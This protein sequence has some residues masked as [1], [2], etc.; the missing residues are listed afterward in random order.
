MD[1]RNNPA[2]IR[3]VD[4]KSVVKIS[5][6]ITGN[7]IIIKIIMEVIK[8]KFIKGI[9]GTNDI[10][11][12]KQ[13]QIAFIGRSNVGK[14]TLI[15]KLIG[16]KGLVKTSGQPGKTQQINFFLI[17]EDLP[18]E[19]YFVDLPG[20]GYAKISQKHREKM[21]K[22]ILWYFISGEANIK[23]V[24]LIIDAKSGLKDFDIEMINVLRE[25]GHDFIII[26]NKVDKLNQKQYHK[27]LMEIKDELGEDINILPVSAK[28][29]RGRDKVLEWIGE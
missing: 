9:V 6:R 21:R 13:D 7:L 4:L 3:I 22:M 25:Y 24:V 10:L 15:N 26:A 11:K 12:D 19:K 14:S 29:G 20:Y 5:G 28:T 17:N 23:K 1:K 8:A 18:G 27:N 16:S 2:M